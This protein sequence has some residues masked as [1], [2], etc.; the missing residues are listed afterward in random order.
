MRSLIARVV[1]TEDELEAVLPRT[2]A[3]DE[4][5]TGVLRL[6][7]PPVPRRGSRDHSGRGLRSVRLCPGATGEIYVMDA[8]GSE[9]TRHTH[10]QS[11]SVDEI[12][13]APASDSSLC[14]CRVVS[15]RRKDRL[16]LRWRDLRRG[17]GR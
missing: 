16:H 12:D 15:P 17:G 2:S 4:R 13:S 5:S 10:D 1:E 11:V 7:S 3:S 8:E 6:S 14:R 9:P